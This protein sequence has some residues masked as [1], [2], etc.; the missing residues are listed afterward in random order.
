MASSKDNS[1]SIII[2]LIIII[3]ATIV[4]VVLLDHNKNKLTS[5]QQAADKSQISSHWKTF[6]A[7]ATP[8]S[9]REVLLQNG[10]KFTQVIQSEFASLNAAK[11]SVTISNVDLTNS[12]TAKVSYNINLNGTPILSGQNGTALLLNNSWKVSDATICGL[13][14][15][16]GSKPTVCKNV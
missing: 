9:Q 2:V 6:F 14:A 5:A 1:L 10:T 7:Y 11:S 12:T 3:I 8:L 4:A 15:M 13:L 16:A